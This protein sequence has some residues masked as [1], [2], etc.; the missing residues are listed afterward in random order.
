MLPHV[1]NSGIEASCFDRM[2]AWHGMLSL[3]DDRKH[4]HSNLTL[5]VEMIGQA[6]PKQGPYSHYLIESERVAFLESVLLPTH[7]CQVLLNCSSSQGVSTSI[8]IS[9]KY[10]WCTAHRVQW[11]LTTLSA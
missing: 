3:L 6:F 5:E 11:L 7:H 2:T 9:S 1:A 4:R 10:K 8:H